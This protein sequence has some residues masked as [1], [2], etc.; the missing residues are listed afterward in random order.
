M[1]GNWTKLTA[2]GRVAEL[3]DISAVM[4]MLDNGLMIEDYSDFSLNGMYGELVDDSILN[5]DRDT[6][7]VSVFIPEERNLFECKSFIS[8]RLAA[9]EIDAQIILE[10]VHT[11]QSFQNKK[12]GAISVSSSICLLRASANT[13]AICIRR[14]SHRQ[15]LHAIRRIM[16]LREPLPFSHL[17]AN[18]FAALTL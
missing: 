9:F 12:R 11:V 4:S 3:E 7:K 18:R 6:V 15:A 1:A 8:E 10:F 5:A 2:T 17:R 16:L 13:F 14:A